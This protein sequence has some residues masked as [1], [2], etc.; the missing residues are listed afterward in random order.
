MLEIV[1]I[2]LD[3][4]SL[5]YLVEAFHSIDGPPEEPCAAEKLA[6]LLIY[7]YSQADFTIS[8][9]V[10]TEY[11]RIRDKKLRAMHEYFCEFVLNT[12]TPTPECGEV[13]S[14]A[15]KLSKFHP[16]EKN[17]NDCKILAECE[18]AK[19]EVLLTYDDPFLKHL[20]SVA[21]DVRM[22]RPTEHWAELDIPRGANPTRGFHPTNPL[23]CAAWLKW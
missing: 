19:I 10:K 4:H 2:A 21:W 15:S 13:L 7:L 18:L 20:Q 17:F 5:T 3:S 22:L 1:S 16:G 6:L 9:T 14:R 8:P 11:K 23:R 12:F